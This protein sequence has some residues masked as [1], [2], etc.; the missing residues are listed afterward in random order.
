MPSVRR[1]HRATLQPK[2]RRIGPLR[3]RTRQPAQ[4]IVQ[5]LR[6]DGCKFCVDPCT[7][8][9][10][11]QTGTINAA[12]HRFYTT[13]GA[14]MVPEGSAS[15]SAKACAPP[16]KLTRRSK[17][18]DPTARAPKRPAPPGRHTV[19]SS[20]AKTAKANWPGYVG[21]NGP[22]RKRP[23]EAS[24]TESWTVGA[25]SSGARSSSHHTR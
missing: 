17:P 15:A 20:S 22:D 7:H 18:Q 25:V 10:E 21:Q 1:G 8:A 11:E 2:S 23:A 5:S 9:A 3:A 12:P 19:R 14:F 24:F 4:T 6:F 16:K 13:G